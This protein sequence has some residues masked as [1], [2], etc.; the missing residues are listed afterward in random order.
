MAKKISLVLGD[1]GK[2]LGEAAT[3]NGHTLSE[4]IRQRLA[5]SLRVK[6]PDVRVG[7]PTF[8]GEQSAQ[9]ARDRWKQN[10]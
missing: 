3:R 9:A 10:R 5:K 1:L 2:P 6:V 7:N 8:G 4:E